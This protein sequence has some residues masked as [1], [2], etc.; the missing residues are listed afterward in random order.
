MFLNS[1]PRKS[2]PPPPPPP[3][4]TNVW[5]MRPGQ[6]SAVRAWFPDLYCTIQYPKL[7]L[8]PSHRVSTQGRRHVFTIGGAR[9]ITHC[10]RLCIEVRSVDQS[11]R[12][13]EKKFRLHFSA[14]RMGSRGTFVL[15]HCKF[16]MYE[17][18]RSRGRHVLL[19]CSNFAR[20]RNTYVHGYTRLRSRSQAVRF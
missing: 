3:P 12:S 11:V 9:Y 16:Q 10:R 5:P 8:S 19:S 7:L 18:C 4:P 1:M 6:S 17:D 20:K 2:S 14:I 15:L 13:V